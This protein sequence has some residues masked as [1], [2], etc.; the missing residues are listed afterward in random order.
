MIRVDAW[1][2]ILRKLSTV[3]KSGEITIITVK[4]NNSITNIA[5][6][7][8]HGSK[9]FS[10]IFLILLINE[11]NTFIHSLSYR[12]LAVKRKI[13]SWSVLLASTI[14]ATLPLLITNILSAMPRSSGISEETIIIPLPLLARS[15]IN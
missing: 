5:L 4:R 13:S 15:I 7:I 1:D 12:Y 3:T 11:L 6:F 9:F 14:P 2:N 10:F 8:T